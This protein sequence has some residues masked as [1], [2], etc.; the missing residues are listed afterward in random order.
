M[1]NLRRNVAVASP[2]SMADGDPVYIQWLGLNFST[3]M[4]DR[5]AMTR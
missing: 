3:A 5:I 4:H 2:L 1:H